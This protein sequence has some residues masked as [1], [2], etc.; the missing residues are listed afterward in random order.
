LLYR[1]LET[2]QVAV[3]N[4]VAVETW[5]RHGFFS[6]TELVY[7]AI[8]RL[9]SSAEAI[10][11]SKIQYHRSRRTS[12]DTQPADNAFSMI[13]EHFPG[14]WLQSKSLGGTNGEASS[15]MSTLDFVTNNI[16]AQGLDFYPGLSEVFDALVVV[17]SLAA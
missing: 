15:T 8:A 10:S 7:L 2:N 13:E 4:P 1:Y 11:R 17:L 12:L 6:L 16:L 9:T 5:L 3:L 14:L